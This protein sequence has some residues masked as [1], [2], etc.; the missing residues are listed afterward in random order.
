MRS[1]SVMV[2]MIATRRRRSDAAGL[3]VARIR[4]QSSSIA[5][6]IA[7]TRRSSCAT[8]SPSAPSPFTS[9][10][11]PSCSCFSTRPPIC[12]TL[13]RT[14]SRSALNRLWMWWERSAVSVQRSAMWLVYLR[15]VTAASAPLKSRGGCAGGHAAAWTWHHRPRR[16]RR[17][18]VFP[19]AIE[20]QPVVI[21]LGAHVLV[22]GVD[23]IREVDGD[24]AHWRIGAAQRPALGVGIAVAE[25]RVD[26]LAKQRVL[27]DGLVHRGRFPGTGI[28][29]APEADTDVV[30]RVLLDVGGHVLR[31]VRPEL[32]RQ[33]ADLRVELRPELPDLV[34]EDQNAAGGGVCRVAIRG[35][36][37]ERR[38]T[39][40]T[41]AVEVMPK[42]DE[43]ARIADRHPEP[44]LRAKHVGVGVFGARVVIVLLVHPPRVAAAEQAPALELDRTPFGVVIVVEE[45]RLARPIVRPGLFSQNEVGALG[46]IP[47][48]IRHVESDRLARAV[49]VEALVRGSRV[50]IFGS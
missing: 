22:E 39:L 1:R 16:R 38:L 21:Q 35:A 3:R 23:E 44:E 11:A 40:A 49:I 17:G 5:T 15:R 25:V 27:V 18:S 47:V 29:R 34:V 7:L 37:E 6:S 28:A 45:Q 14:P 31:V 4:L 20:L 30:G 36:V 50:V 48:G 10:R 33:G 43:I 41:T 26:E 2:L 19:V 42:A 9:A 24:V 32:Q 12:S 8:S 13:A 46:E